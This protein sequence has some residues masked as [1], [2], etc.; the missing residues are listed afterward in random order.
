[1]DKLVANEGHWRMVLSNAA[2]VWS[3]IDLSSATEW[4]AALPE[5]PVR[6]GAIGGM[7]EEMSEYDA[8]AALT[9]IAALKQPGWATRDLKGIASELQQQFGSEG[10]RQA[11]RRSALTD[12]EKQ[13]TLK[14]IR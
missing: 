4:A 3:Q 7:L 12:V 6:D 5:G 11:I 2:W 9:W 8:E 13:E 1:M 14:A 10:A